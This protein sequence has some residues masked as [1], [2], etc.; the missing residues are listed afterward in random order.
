MF[1]VV[2]DNGLGGK[3]VSSRGGVDLQG[4][5]G[6]QPKSDTGRPFLLPTRD[7]G[8]MVDPAVRCEDR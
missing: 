6:F 8:P 4:A 3:P 7:L 2:G 1:F 5:H